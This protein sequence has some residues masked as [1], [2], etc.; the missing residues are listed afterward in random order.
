MERKWL[1]K[2]W[3]ISSKMLLMLLLGILHQYYCTLHSLSSNRLMKV[4]DLLW[5]FV[6]PYFKDGMAISVR[7][8]FR[9]L[10]TSKPRWGFMALSLPSMPMIMK[11]EWPC[12]MVMPSLISGDDSQMMLR[13]TEQSLGTKSFVKEHTRNTQGK[14][15]VSTTL[16]RQWLMLGSS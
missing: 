5:T 6:C 2:I 3:L 11:I 15:I 7:K 14:I 1:F 9:L 13:Q 12:L 16:P 4:R 10:C 8:V